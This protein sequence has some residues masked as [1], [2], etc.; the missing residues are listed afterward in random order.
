MLNTLV[1]LLL[2]SV[3]AVPVSRWAGFGSVPGYLVGG[4]VIGPVGLGLVANSGRY[5]WCH[6]LVS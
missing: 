5:R 2:A 3:V 1:A 6:N 4:V